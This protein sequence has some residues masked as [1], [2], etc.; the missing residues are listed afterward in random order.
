METIFLFLQVDSFFNNNCDSQRDNMRTVTHHLV[1]LNE[2][3]FKCKPAVF[4]KARTAEAGGGDVLFLLT[5]LLWY[6]G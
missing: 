1:Y 4:K 6:L 3:V 5:Y 2:C